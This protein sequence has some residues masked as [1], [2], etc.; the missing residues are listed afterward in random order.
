VSTPFPTSFPAG[1][2]AP[3]A[4][5]IPLPVPPVASAGIAPE[6]AVVELHPA[7]APIAAGLSDGAP[8][9]A[10]SGNFRVY[11]HLAHGERIEVGTH[12]TESAAKAEATALMRFLRDERG[13]WPFLGGRFVRPE[14]IVSVDVESA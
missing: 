12:E 7:P 13:D 8:A 4:Q 3:A 9:P 6:R 2:S 1:P 14:A 10:L 5:P 11:A